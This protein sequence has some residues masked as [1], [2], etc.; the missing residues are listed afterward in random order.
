MPT[1]VQDP[2]KV[3]YGSDAVVSGRVGDMSALPLKADAAHMVMMSP[4]LCQ[5]RVINES[6]SVANSAQE[7]DY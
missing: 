3:R 7:T 4:L 2:A 5:L 1:A 6:G